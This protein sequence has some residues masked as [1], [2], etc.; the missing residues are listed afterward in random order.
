MSGKS[1]E[2]RNIQ[3][4]SVSVPC[5]PN[6][7]IMQQDRT[8]LFR[9]LDAVTNRLTEGLRV[10][11]DYARFVRDEPSATSLL[12][13]LR[14]QVHHL[15]SPWLQ[16]LTA[17][18][19]TPGD[20]GCPLTAESER[21]RGSFEHI[22]SANCKRVEQSL[23]SLEEYGKLLD[24]R[25][26]ASAKQLRYLFYDVETKLVSGFSERR[27][28]LHQARLYVLVDGG[29][30][31]EQ[32]QERCRVIAQAGADILQLRDKTLNDR[33]LWERACQLRQIT[34]ETQTIFIVN[35]RPDIALA[36]QADGVHVGQEELPLD[37]VRT[38]T[39]RNYLVG[40]STHNEEQLQAACRAGA[41]Y[42]GCGPT[43]RSTTKD[44]THYAGLAFLELAAQI[45][46]CPAFAIGGI[47]LEN[48]RQVLSTGIRRV[49][50]S[51]AIW[52][53]ADPA[54][55]THAFRK[56]LDEAPL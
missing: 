25:L 45:C 10:L 46:T 27:R 28:R 47:T 56:I 5:P 26:A 36:S 51:A 21:T 52:H 20:V 33:Q 13:E 34:R 49:A 30:T 8:K 35:D 44:F 40:V 12:K 37:V 7:E 55:A 24:E 14:H 32:F 1:P 15:L 39:G 53:A 17:A 19:N 41:D 11:E 43:F 23:R 48:V 31:V 50:V 16:E 29:P 4:E 22:I 2:N 6:Q 9:L 54:T 42:V 38:L 18:R 3:S